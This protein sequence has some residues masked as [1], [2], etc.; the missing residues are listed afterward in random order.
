VKT[1][2]AMIAMTLASCGYDASFNDCTTSCSTGVCPSGLECVSSICRVPGATGTC[3]AMSGDGAVDTPTGDGVVDAPSGDA[4]PYY[5]WGTATELFSLESV[6]GGETGPSFTADLMTVVFSAT[7]PTN[8]EQLYIAT[9]TALTDTFTI[10][11]LT[12]LNATGFNDRSPEI[13]A[14][15]T[16]LYFSSNRSGTYEI[17]ASTFTTSWSAPTVRTDLSSAGL[18]VDLAVS[19]DGLTAAVSVDA[20]QNTIR[21]LTRTTTAD[22]FSNA[23]THSELEIDANIGAPTITNGGEVIYLHAATPRQLYRATRTGSGT[24]TTPAPVVELNVAATSTATPCVSQSDE[25]MM[26]EIAG[27]IYQTSRDLP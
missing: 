14:D 17:Y 11:E 1:L 22:P 20:A 3:P 16:T 24:Y 26:F 23:M 6:G 7:V 27:D 15:G 8:D 9:R 2:V 10:N 19:P 5:A 4:G 18:D 25:Y 21:I 12:T 13:S